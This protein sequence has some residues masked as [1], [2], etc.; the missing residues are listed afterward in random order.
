MKLL[1]CDLCDEAFAAETFEEWMQFM[2]PHYMA[3]HASYMEAGKDKPKEEQ[4][5]WM[6]DN[7]ARFDAA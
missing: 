7:R 5:K 4:A 3:E 2:M 6:A 1:S